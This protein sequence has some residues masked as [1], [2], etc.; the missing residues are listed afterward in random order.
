MLRPEKST[1]WVVFHLELIHTD[2]AEPEWE[3][4]TSNLSDFRLFFIPI[5]ML[6][7]SDKNLLYQLVVIVWNTLDFFDQN[8]V[9]I[10]KCVKVHCCLCPIRCGNNQ[11][12]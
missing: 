11:K 12:H 1:C 4:R 8:Q 7:T 3:V 6:T 5:N 9:F 10:I 2:G